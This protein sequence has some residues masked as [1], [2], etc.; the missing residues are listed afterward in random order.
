MAL[1][2]VGVLDEQADLGGVVRLAEPAADADDVPVSRSSITQERR[3]G[4]ERTTSV[5]CA[6]GK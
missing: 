6:A 4:D 1:A 5:R 2:L 3:K